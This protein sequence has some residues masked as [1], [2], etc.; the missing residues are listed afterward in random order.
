MDQESTEE[1]VGLQQLF[2]TPGDYLIPI[3]ASNTRDRSFPLLPPSAGLNNLSSIF[4]QTLTLQ[5][6]DLECQSFCAEER[7]QE[8]QVTVTF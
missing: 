4:A 6:D 2:F 7:G 1:A 5:G 8:L 3:I